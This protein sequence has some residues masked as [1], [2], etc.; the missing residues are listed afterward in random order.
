MQ[1][2][3]YPWRHAVIDDYFPDAI[4]Q[5]LLL[6]QETFVD[7]YRETHM[8]NS[9]LA[10]AQYE[11]GS[12]LWRNHPDPEAA[13]KYFENTYP[14]LNALYGVLEEFF[15]KRHNLLIEDL[16]HHFQKG[17]P[18]GFAFAVQIQAPNYRYPIHND[19]EWKKLSTTVFLG[20]DNVGTY[21]YETADQDYDKPSKV[22]EWKPNRALVFSRDENTFHSFNT[23]SEEKFRYTL[24][25][26]L[27]G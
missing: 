15:R 3:D 22:I 27:R 9:H 1:F 17:R 19:S 13:E 14:E 10:I 25:H 11:D 23:T 24:V 26:N 5:E 8:M 18:E 20:D 16:Y 12:R 2:F 4:F 6:N 21:L 7:Y